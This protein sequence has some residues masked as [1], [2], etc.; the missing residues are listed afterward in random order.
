MSSVSRAVVRSASVVLGALFL[1]ACALNLGVKIPLGAAE[2]SFSAPSVDIAAYE[3]SIGLFLMAASALS[4]LYVYAGAYLFASVG[5]AEGLLSPGLAGQALDLHE[6]MLPFLLVGFVVLG[7]EGRTA[8]L[9]KRVQP[10]DQ[11]NQGVVT[12]LQFFVGGLVTLGGAAYARFG[13]YPFGTAL[14]LVHLAVGLAGLLGGYIVYRREPRARRF[15]IVVNLVTIAWSAFSEGMA[16]VFSLLTPGINDS[17][18]GT[19]VAVLVSAEIIYMLRNNVAAT[20]I[21]RAS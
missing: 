6:A 21:P 18:I 17:L 13:T 4:R 14:G 19:I 7:V 15:L 16:Q 12:A 11:F 9:S 2:L 3:G 1:L 8:Y 5:I 20:T 10:R